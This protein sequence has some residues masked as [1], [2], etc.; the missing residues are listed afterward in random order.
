LAI[1]DGMA[2]AAGHDPS[3]PDAGDQP[4]SALY[5]DLILTHHRS[6]RHRGTLEAPTAGAHIAN[7]TC[8]DAVTVALR[9]R[10]GII[11]A[12]RFQG[13]GCAISL[14]AASMMASLVEGMHLEEAHA[15]AIRS[16][17]LMRGEDGVRD[18]DWD[19]ALGDLRAL[20]SVARF[21]ARL[22]CALLPFE[23]LE[24]AAG[25]AG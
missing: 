15:L 5:Q 10:D 21:P 18:S 6:P 22:R 2:G 17:A 23:A 7:P 11:E 12:I 4:L 14:A 16:P 9:V 24:A 8:G 1:S 20:A 25:Q 13:E 19:P 3:G